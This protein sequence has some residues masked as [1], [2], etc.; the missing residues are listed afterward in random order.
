MKKLIKEKVDKLEKKHNTTNPLEL[1]SCLG[2]F[3]FKTDLGKVKGF[4]QIEDGVKMIHLN[5]NLNY[6]E[7]LYTCAH[8]IGHALLHKHLNTI[9][10]ENKTFISTNRL[11]N[12]ANL[13]AVELLLRNVSLDVGIDDQITYKYLSQISGIPLDYLL[14]K[15]N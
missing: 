10:L 5:S 2:I 4:L 1:C 12:E 6:R 11:E 9:F 7:Q 8:E 14:L 15:Y 13:F 3:V